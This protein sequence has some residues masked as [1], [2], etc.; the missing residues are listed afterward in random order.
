MLLYYHIKFFWEIKRG[1]EMSISA[2]VFQWS[3]LCIPAPHQAVPPRLSL[4]QHPSWWHEGHG[5]HFLSCRGDQRS[6]PHPCLVESVMAV[7][8]MLS[9]LCCQPEAKNG[10]KLK[11]Q[12]RDDT[13]YS[14]SN[15][16][17]FPL[18]LAFTFCR[19]SGHLQSL[20]F[21]CYISKNV[22]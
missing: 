17:F 19:F 4:Q 20:S 16:T 2:K 5:G 9:E 3:V 13:K 12:P 18:V 8:K 21:L 7:L 22:F 1:F 14:Y 6:N 10:A 15:L 11:V